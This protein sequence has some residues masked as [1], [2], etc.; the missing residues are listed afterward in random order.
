MEFF[1][2][3]VPTKNK[4]CTMSFKG[5]SND[6]L[7]TLDEAHKFD[8]YAGIL[9]DDAILI[10]IDDYDHNG[11]LKYGVELSPILLQMIEEHNVI[12]RVY[13]ANRGYHFLFKNTK[14]K[15]CAT[16]INLACG[17]VADI[18]VGSQNSYEVLKY[19]GVERKIIYDKFDDEKYDEIPKWLYPI[20]S[21][22]DFINMR[23][24][25]GRNQTLFNY[26]LTLQSN[27]FTVDE[28]RET[29]SIL[30]KYVLRN[31]LDERELAVIMRNDAFKKES[32]FSGNTFLFDKFSKYLM[33]NAYIRKINEKLH[34]YKEGIYV[35]GS[36]YIEQEM[37]NN[38]EHLNRSKR[39]EVLAYLDLI[40]PSIEPSDARYIAFNNGIYD[41]VDNKMLPFTPE[42]VITNK[43]PY[44][45]V[46]NSYHE[47]CDITL[48]KLACYDTEI[49]A[50]LEEAIGY[51]FYRRNEL[52]KS[53]ILIGDKAN[54]KS[55]FLDLI[56]KLLG[57]INTSALDL[58]EIGH[59]FRTAEIFN[60][61][62]NI[63]DDIEDEFIS[64]AAL[65]KKVVSGSVITVEKKGKDPYK[66]HPYTKFLFSANNIPRIKDKT[67]AVLDRLVIIPFNA[68][69][70][71]DD[72]DFD[73]Y[74]KYKLLN[75]EVMKYLIVIGLKGLK[76]VLSKKAFTISKKVINEI[77]AYEKKNNPVLLFFEEVKVEDIINHTNTEVY[78]RYSA[79]SSQNGFQANSI[80]EFG[81]K[82]TKYFDLTTKVTKVDGKTQRIYVNK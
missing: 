25:D 27:E 43:I 22:I 40:V 62:A 51:C 75:E 24:G 54:G 82:I 72:P 58:N 13:K 10:D 76:R 1:R 9:A 20:K 29:L 28:C 33:S 69:F 80:V 46:P 11:N 47:L 50:L 70:S 74:I 12:C 79:W 61:L 39:A 67:G 16:A 21:N 52:R 49:R 45:Y 81:R 60:K 64:G 38:I 3:Y 17:L 15:K 36:L 19:N 57:E 59:Q 23:E 5:K 63:G 55:T 26:I 34:I 41:I 4:K 31:P 7:L 35:D 14:V 53:F 18:K 48:N 30:N 78:L 2:A 56:G 66:F 32:F 68:T 6:E 44:D 37:I 8:E 42:I 71:P 65:F 73:P 77:S